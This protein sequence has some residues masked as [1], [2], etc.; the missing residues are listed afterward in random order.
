MS[1]KTE[2]E[3]IVLTKGQC[4]R[5]IQITL[6]NKV[7]ESGEKIQFFDTNIDHQG[8]S[9][10]ERPH[11]FIIMCSMSEWDQIKSVLDKNLKI[12]KDSKLTSWR[13]G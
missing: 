1:E 4:K 5:P 13:L 2:L 6:K 10:N 9:F 12:P 7:L 11:F 3:K 8:A